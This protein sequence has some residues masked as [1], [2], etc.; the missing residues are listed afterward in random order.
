MT[1]LTG[2][3]APA[4][5]R[6]PRKPGPSRTGP[7]SG[8]PPGPPPGPPAVSALPTGLAAGA[9]AALGGLAL[10]AAPVLLLW[11]VSPYVQDGAGGAVHLAACLWLLAH[12]ADLVRATA[13]GPDAPT[14][15]VGVVP[16]LLTAAVLALLHRAGRRTGRALCDAAGRP[17]GTELPLRAV[18]AALPAVC[19]GYAAVAA[20]AAAVASG[21]A[22]L[23]ARPVPALAAAVLVAVVGAAAGLRSAVRP[24]RPEAP[25]ALLRLRALLRRP[26]GPAGPPPGRWS[27]WSS[28][29]RWRPA[30]RF[31]PRE[32]AVPVLRAALAGWAALAGV[33]A[34]VLGASLLLHGDAAGRAV[35]ALA[36]DLPGQAGLVL[37]CLSLYPDAVVWSAS[38][39]LGPGFALGGGTVAPYA[40]SP[41]P[42]PGLPL[43]AALPLPG[44]HG[45]PGPLGWA[46]LALP[47]LAGAALGAVLG[48]AAAGRDWHPAATAV[49]ACAAA[50]AAGAAFAACAA[51]SGGAL[52]TERLAVLGPP[53][54]PTGA[55]AAAWTAAS[56]APVA[57]LVRWVLRRRAVR[58]APG[59]PGGD[60][61]RRRRRT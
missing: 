32:A 27:R 12:G 36:P 56:G 3:R 38:Y 8:A 13:S 47:P 31:F 58:A 54:W 51:A 40:A 48:R 42:V 49:A 9:A 61:H 20:V 50:L 19:G 11:V 57:L 55:A 30:E 34:A 25:R 21:D 45:V 1:S 28:R 24:R 22:G 6:T 39:A 41:G 14:A 17:Y 26:D 60:A 46:A 43:L 59:A 2:G 37:L 52:G 4:T 29:G 18:A 35:P 44:P 15:P 10:T 7:P 16:L 5:P 33:G 23:R 53:P